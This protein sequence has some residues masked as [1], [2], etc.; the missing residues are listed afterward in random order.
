MIVLALSFLATGWIL[1]SMIAM[2]LNMRRASAM[3]IPLIRLYIE[4]QNTLWMIIEPH[5]WPWLDKLPLNWG[6]FGRYSRRGWFFADKGESHRRYGPVFALVT[7]RSIYVYVAQAEATNEMFQR[8]ADFVRPVE[9]Y[10]R[11][12]ALHSR[13]HEQC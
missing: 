8:R 12:P 4:P 6:T 5:L 1:W 9:Q 13:K 2:E 7:P 11:F 10:S 3:N